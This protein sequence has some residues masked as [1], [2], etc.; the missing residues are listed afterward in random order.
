MYDILVNLDDQ[1]HLDY[2]AWRIHRVKKIIQILGIDWFKGKT[3]LDLACGQGH[4]SSFFKSIGANVIAADARQEHLASILNITTMQ[5]DQDAPWQLEEKVDL[6]IHFG[7]LYHLKN[8]K[9]DLAST[10]K[11][12][13][14]FFLES[15]VANT[16]DPLFEHNL[17]EEDGGGQNAYNKIGTVMS[18][19]NVERIL[20]ELGC[21]FQRYDDE[22]LSIPNKK[23]YQYHWTVTNQITDYKLAKDFEDPAIYGGRRF[24]L[25]YPNP[26]IS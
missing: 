24:W 19:A 4:I 22:D 25:V 6:S 14:I 15:V 26:S 21:K 10:A 16:D 11:S 1:F 18:A 17:Y 8:W 12:S 23:L 13:K 9:Q 7:V 3:V 2:N 5:I 20:T